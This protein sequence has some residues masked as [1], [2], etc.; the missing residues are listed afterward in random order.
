MAGVE[1]DTVDVAAVI[2]PRTVAA[3]RAALMKVVAAA[4]VVA[5][6]LRTIMTPATTTAAATGTRQVVTELMIPIRNL[7]DL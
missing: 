7:I 4:E 6:T 3:I 5:A 1:A 2:G